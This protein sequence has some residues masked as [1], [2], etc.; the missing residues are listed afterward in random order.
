MQNLTLVQKHLSAF[1]NLHDKGSKN[2]TY[3]LV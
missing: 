2:F 3:N 1:R